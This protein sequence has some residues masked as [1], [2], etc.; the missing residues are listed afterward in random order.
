MRISIISAIAEG[1]RAIGKDNALLW[2]IPE[3]MK[4]FRELTTGH[5]VIMGQ[6]T[7]ESIGRPLPNR[8]NIVLSKDASLVIPGCTV[9]HS[10]EEALSEAEKASP[11][12]SFVIGG[13]MVYLAALPLAD[14][15]YLTVVKGVFEGDT[16]FPEYPAFTEVVSEERG[17]NGEYD[18]SFMILE[19]HV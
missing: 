4:R 1:N 17:G 2:H 11:E 14:R 12:E 5:A 6:K 18:F 13:G 19:K 15:L 8:T 9:C 3:D 10:L 16:F 7:Y